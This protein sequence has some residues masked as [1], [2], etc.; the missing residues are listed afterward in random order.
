MAGIAHPSTLTAV[1]RR[2][3]LGLLALICLPALLAAPAARATGGLLPVESFGA[4]GHMSYLE[5]LDAGS[6]LQD[7]YVAGVLDTLEL[8]FAQAEAFA[9]AGLDPR[10]VYA[11]VYE[12]VAGIP[13]DVA[14]G[15]IRESILADLSATRANGNST[16]VAEGPA[17]LA[18]WQSLALHHCCW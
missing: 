17:V 15:A 3:V 4:R 6:A 13:E 7:A 11:I 16:H 14:R 2:L 18:V 9:D 8:I 1:R 10:S 12:A 5:F